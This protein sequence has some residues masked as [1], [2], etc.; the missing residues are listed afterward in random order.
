M[1]VFVYGR[2]MRRL[3]ESESLQVGCETTVR[4]DMNR[5]LALLSERA[6]AP[7]LPCE[8]MAGAE[9]WP[10][11]ILY[12]RAGRRMRMCLSLVEPE[13]FVWGGRTEGKS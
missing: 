7:L 10:D 3:D 1:A 8:R 13:S 11:F 2:R 6:A 4:G 5:F 12:A 9:C